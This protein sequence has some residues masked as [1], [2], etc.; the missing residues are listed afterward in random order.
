MAS[1]HEKAGAKMS[2]LTVAEWVVF[3]LALLAL[4]LFFTGR[5]AL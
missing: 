5:L 3:L 2:N 4:V 1:L